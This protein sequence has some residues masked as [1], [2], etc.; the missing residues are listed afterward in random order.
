VP[1]I[2]VVL[3]LFWKC[4]GNYTLKGSKARPLLAHELLVPHIGCAAAAALPVWGHWHT[5]KTQ[6]STS[7][8]NFRRCVFDLVAV[9][10]STRAQ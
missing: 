7:E 4:G 9:V 10:Y 5:I 6:G 8:E 1:H 2:A 3:L